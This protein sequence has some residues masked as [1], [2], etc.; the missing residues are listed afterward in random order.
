MTQDRSPQLN[1]V[2]NHHGSRKAGWSKRP[3][4]QL[5]SGAALLEPSFPGHQEMSGYKP[6]AR[7][8]GIFSQPA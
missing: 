2:K 5:E 7:N 1:P 6:F 4:T 3:S 8:A